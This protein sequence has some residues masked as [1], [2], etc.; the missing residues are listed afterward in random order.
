MTNGSFTWTVDLPVGLSVG[1]MFYVLIDNIIPKGGSATTP[2][3]I[4][5]PGTS[6]TCIA[7]NNDR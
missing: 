1:M 4:V 6:S 3:G 2:Y 7:Q 5:Q